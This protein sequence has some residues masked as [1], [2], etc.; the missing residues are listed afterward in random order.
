MGK[1]K[2]YQINP[3]LEENIIL[4]KSDFWSHNAETHSIRFS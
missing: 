4:A 2:L 3:A 1:K